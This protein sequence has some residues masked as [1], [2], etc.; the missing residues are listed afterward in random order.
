MDALQDDLTAISDDI[1][2][3]LVRGAA[4]RRNAFHL[5][6]VA[7]LRAGAPEQRLMVLRATSI[8]Q[9]CLRFHTDTRTHKVADLALAPAVSILFYDPG[10]KLQLRL[11]GQARIE[12][13]TAVVDQAW[14]NTSQYGRRCYLGPSAPGSPVSAP[15]S[16]LPDDVEGGR[17]DWDR[18]EAGR[19]VF[20]VLLATINE[21]EWLYLAHHGHR[22]A[23]F[24]FETN[25]WTGTWLVP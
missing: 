17:P 23:L 18:T 21:I 8:E 9:R 25:G 6:A 10:A 3:R 13:S 4:D 7:T 19:P 22:R 11:R 20:G 24:H 12:A 2:R 15:T 1:W 16:G 5:G 14:I